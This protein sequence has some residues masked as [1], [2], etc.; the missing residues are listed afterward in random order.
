MVEDKWTLIYP[1]GWC[2]RRRVWLPLWPL[3]G[4]QRRDERLPDLRVAMFG[5]KRSLLGVGIFTG[6]VVAPGTAGEWQR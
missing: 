1:G 2:S 6:G 5:L 4:R 3:Y